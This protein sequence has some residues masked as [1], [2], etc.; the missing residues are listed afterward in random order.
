MEYLIPSRIIIIADKIKVI[1]LLEISILD[2]DKSN[3]CNE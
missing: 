1:H 3:H 2:F